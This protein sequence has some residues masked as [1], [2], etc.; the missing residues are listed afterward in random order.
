METGLASCILGILVIS[1]D[2]CIL[3]ALLL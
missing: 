2:S 1:C 3:E